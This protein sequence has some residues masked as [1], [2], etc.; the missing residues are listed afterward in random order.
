MKWVQMSEHV[1]KCSIWLIIPVNVWLVRSDTGLTLVDAGIPSMAKG[2]LRQIGRLEMPLEQIVL[3]HGH[4]DHVG[5]LKRILET[6]PVPVYAHE[7]EIPYME[8]S[9]PYPRRKKAEATVQ[10]GLAAPLDMQ[11]RIGGLMPYATPGHSPGH[12]AYFHEQD[13][14]LLAGDLFTSKRGQLNRP[15]PMFTADM[16]QAVE[17]GAIVEQLAPKLVSVCHGGDVVITDPKQQVAAYRSISL[18][19][20]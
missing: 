20:L 18:A 5:S 3:T 4:S 15:M 7:T 1:W 10:P 16:K 17:S 14:V 8:G 9:M 12:T 2:L 6:Y 11:T 19:H 13:R